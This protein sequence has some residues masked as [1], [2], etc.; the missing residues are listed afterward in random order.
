M[1]SQP[2]GPP[3]PSESTGLVEPSPR[4]GRRLVG[5]VF[6]PGVVLVVFVLILAALVER[7]TLERIGVGSLSIQF[8]AQGTATAPTDPGGIRPQASQAQT[9][10]QQAGALP[11]FAYNY[12]GEEQG[13]NGFIDTLYLCDVSQR[14]S[15]ITGAMVTGDPEG[16]GDG[17]FVGAVG[18]SGSFSLNVPEPFQ[19]I[20][21]DVYQGSLS[22]DG[23]V[24]GTFKYDNGTGVTGTWTVTPVIGSA[25]L[26]CGQGSS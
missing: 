6:T 13:T 18:P 7:F 2:E 19:E 22:A 24:V 8:G 23:E 10:A 1:T 3:S 26:G 9:V 11:A 4:K 14:G 16:D 25:P 12:E 15:L 21:A 20:S 17:Q 5:R